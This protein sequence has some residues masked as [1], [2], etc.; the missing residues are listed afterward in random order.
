MDGWV[1]VVSE[2]GALILEEVGPASDQGT[3]VAAEEEEDDDED[4]GPCVQR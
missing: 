1:S 3:N 4:E 2:K